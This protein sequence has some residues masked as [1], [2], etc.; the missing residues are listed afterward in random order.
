M[1]LSVVVN[2]PGRSA[3]VWQISCDFSRLRVAFTQKASIF[4]DICRFKACLNNNF[5]RIWTR[6]INIIV[7]RTLGMKTSSLRFRWINFL[8][9]W[10]QLFSLYQH[11]SLP[12]RAINYSAQECTE[13]LCMATASI[14]TAHSDD[15]VASYH[16][17]SALVACHS[18]SG[19]NR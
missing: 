16:H 4:C 9:Q 3:V 19:R 5:I 6:C 1:R 18:C 7:N 8:F 2:N 11:N 15:S 17:S 12:A 10:S 13:W 14:F